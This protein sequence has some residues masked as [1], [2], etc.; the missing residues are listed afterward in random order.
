MQAQERFARNLRNRR[1]E[2]GLS[3]EDVAHESGL[4][5]T[6]VSRLERAVREPRLSTMV[7]LAKA[8]ETT[9]ADLVSGVEGGR[10]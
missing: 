5:A 1:L 6:E 2:I 10:S 4:H 9:V 3:Q 7:R 8:L